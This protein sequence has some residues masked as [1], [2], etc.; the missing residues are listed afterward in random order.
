MLFAGAVNVLVA[1][2]IDWRRFGFVEC[3][4]KSRE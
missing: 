3:K 4:S 2:I 1:V